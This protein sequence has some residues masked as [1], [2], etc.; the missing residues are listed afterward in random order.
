[1]KTLK[2]ENQIKELENLGIKGFEMDAYDLQD[3]LSTCQENDIYDIYNRP[4]YAKV[5]TWAN[6]KKRI[7]AMFKD[8]NIDVVYISCLRGTSQL[9]TIG[10]KLDY[11]DEDVFLKITR[12]HIRYFRKLA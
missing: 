7:E 1:M 3:M 12:N 5:T 11:D 4:S 2:S 9:Y 8:S 6:W 10:V